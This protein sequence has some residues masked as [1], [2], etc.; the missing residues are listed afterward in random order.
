MLPL[1]L[2]LLVKLDDPLQW[3]EDFP[4]VE[5]VS[6]GQADWLLE[7]VGDRLTL[8]H[9]EGLVNPL[10]VDWTAGAVGHRSHQGRVLH[11]SLVKAVGVSKGNRA[12]WDWSLGLASDAWML[13][14][15]GCQVVGYE[16]NPIIF[17]LTKD[18]WQ[19]AELQLGA[20]DIDIHAGEPTVHGP[21]PDAI[22]FDPMFPASKK[23]AKVKGPMQVLQLLNDGTVDDS[24]LWLERAIDAGPKRVV[25]K[26]PAQA[27]PIEGSRAPTF[28]I[29]GKSSRFDVY[30]L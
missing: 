15:A 8:I 18:A 6:E 20:L 21:P 4:C 5:I 28:Q 29:T 7:R 17:Q 10:A 23:Q 12:I 25:V 9:G 26:R 11:E 22:Y 27:A 1:K 2:A 16:R 13:A 19:R 3:W 14:N 30:Q 24:A